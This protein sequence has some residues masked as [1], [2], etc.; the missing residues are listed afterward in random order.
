MNTAYADSY[1]F[2][3]LLSRQDAGHLAA[4]EFHRTFQGLIVTSDWILLEVA[5]AL[6]SRSKRDSVVRLISA[7]MDNR[8]YKVVHENSFD[9]ERGFKL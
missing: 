8:A 6:A 2:L 9:F 4:A 5:D 1:Y 7:I 3:A